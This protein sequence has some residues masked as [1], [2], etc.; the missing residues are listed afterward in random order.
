[1]RKAAERDAAKMEQDKHDLAE[2]RRNGYPS[3][4]PG[5]DYIMPK[6]GSCI[7]NNGHYLDCDCGVYWPAYD[8]RNGHHIKYYLDRRNDWQTAANMC[9]TKRTVIQ[10]GGS[11]GLWAKGLAEVF[12]TVYTFEPHPDLYEC[13]I[14]NLAEKRNVIKLQA[15]VGGFSGVTEM[16]WKSF[17]SHYIKQPDVD[18][19]GNRPTYPVIRID[20]LDLPNCDLILLDLEG[21][22]YC[23]LM[24]AWDTIKKHQ[25]II[26]VE[27]FGLETRRGFEEGCVES[28]LKHL[29]YVMGDKVGDDRLYVP[30]RIWAFKSG[31]R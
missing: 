29:G 24:G 30:K 31:A 16:V 2:R 23:A 5:I 10:A 11:V 4:G 13:M 19:R 12:D 15:C 9:S 8:Q 20:S 18:S 26:Q 21:Y 6:Q 3:H 27:E 14:H 22:E 17:G 7:G 25:P 28:L 1:M